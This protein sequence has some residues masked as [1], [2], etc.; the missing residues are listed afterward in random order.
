MQDTKDTKEY[1]TEH[2]NQEFK[3]CMV[4]SNEAISD[5][6]KTLQKEF[7]ANDLSNEDLN[8]IGL[9]LINILAENLKMKVNYKNV[10]I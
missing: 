5:L 10:K 7:G 4:L 1:I 6:G 9:L 8:K 3:S 2:K